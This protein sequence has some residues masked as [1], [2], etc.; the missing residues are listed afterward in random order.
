MKNIFFIFQK[1]PSPPL[2]GNCTKASLTLYIDF[3]GSIDKALIT[4]AKI[5]ADLRSR[6]LHCQTKVQNLYLK[7]GPA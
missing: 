2:V 1:Q 7:I 5:S 6:W 3:P 4:Q